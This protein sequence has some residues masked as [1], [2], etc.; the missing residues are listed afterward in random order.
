MR[1][2]RMRLVRSHVTFT[3]I[4]MRVKKM[5]FNIEHADCNGSTYTVAYEFSELSLLA[6]ICILVLTVNMAIGL[7]LIFEC[8]FPLSIFGSLCGGVFIAC[9]FSFMKGNTIY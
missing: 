6:V 8:T 9:F 7:F 2:L 4:S 1:C 5:K 3:C